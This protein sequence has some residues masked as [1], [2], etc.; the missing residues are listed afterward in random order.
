MGTVKYKKEDYAGAQTDLQKSIDAYPQQPDPVVV[1]R[2]AL[3]LDKQN[4]YPEALKAANRAVELTQDG[5]QMGTLARR[6]RDRLQQLT[7]GAAAP[8]QPAAQPPKN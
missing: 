7:G 2:L 1:L 8:A 6:E 4:K 5:S 3:S